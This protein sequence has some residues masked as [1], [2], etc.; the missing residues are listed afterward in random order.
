MNIV[1][2][3]SPDFSATIL[4]ALLNSEHNVVAVYTQPDKPVG[5][6]QKI[7]VSK[8]KSIA[9]EHDI[10][11]QQP[12]SLKAESEQ[13]I[14]DGYNAD[15]MVVVAYGLILPEAILNTPRFGCINIHTSLLPRW[16]GAA[17]IQR[18]IE[19]G[20][21]QT[22]VTIMQMD[23][24]LDTGDMLHK[25]LIEIADDETSLS[26]FS[27][28][29]PLSITAL[30]H[31]L[32][33]YQSL[34]AEAIKQDDSQAN[35]AA[36]ISKDEAQI[37]WQESAI[38]I[39]RKIRAFTPWPICF[40][41]LDE[42]TIRVWQAAPI[43]SSDNSSKNHAPGTIIEHHDDALIIACAENSALAIQEMQLPNKPRKSF[44]AL[45]NG[46]AELF[47]PGKAFV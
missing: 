12:S 2:A 34:S 13:A 20:D 24:G 18:A 43:H 29:E 1:F 8:V 10:P 42:H 14:L 46:Y 19:A 44:S 16:R 35:Y 17:P 6:G 27:K 23:A 37:N 45:K 26:L 11:V 36:K 38:T 3:G 39:D 15:I 4:S 7:K 47:K 32:S 33:N 31:T 25:E 5:R 22:G 30:L 28:L 21:A 40:S 41:Q 9:L